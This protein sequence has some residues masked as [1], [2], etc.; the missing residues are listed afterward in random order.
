MAP[1]ELRSSEFMGVDV[2]KANALRFTAHSEDVPQEA[3]L[4]S[5][6]IESVF[7][8]FFFSSFISGSGSLRGN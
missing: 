2:S 1:L 4:Q 5:A 3:R 7:F 8:C 6:S